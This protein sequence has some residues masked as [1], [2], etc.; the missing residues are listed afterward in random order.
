MLCHQDDIVEAEVLVRRDQR[1]EHN[2]SNEFSSKILFGNFS[3]KL[4]QKH[5]G[6]FTL[7]D[8]AV[9]MRFCSVRLGH[10]R[11]PLESCRSPALVFALHGMQR[12][13]MAHADP[14]P[15]AVVLVCNPLPNCGG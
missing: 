15:T 1:Q 4:G 9:L 13:L 11:H 12:A 8:G 6:R 5:G 2:N 3:T 14:R 10:G 7:V